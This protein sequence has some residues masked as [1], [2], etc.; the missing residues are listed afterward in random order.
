MRKTIGFFF[1]GLSASALACGGDD[2]H[3]AAPG[4]AASDAPASD[5]TNGND[6]APPIDGG[7]DAPVPVDANVDSAPPIT[8][9]A[10][11]TMTNASGGNHV[12]AFVRKADGSLTPFGAPFST[13]GTGSGQPLGSQGAIALDVGT[14]RLYAVNAG[15]G[16]FSVFPVRSDGSLAKALKVPG[17][18]ALVGPK[19]IT[20]SSDTVYVLYEGDATHPSAIAGY[21]VSGVG[22][23]AGSGVPIATSTL[24]LSNNTQSV[25]PAQIAFTPDGAYLV[26][27]EK[28]TNM[29]DTFSVDGTGLATKVGFYPTA[30]LGG[31][32]GAEQT[33]YGLAISGKV[34][35]VSEAASAGVGTYMLGVTGAV[36]PAGGGVQFL[37]TDPA[38]C[39]VASANG[40][41]YVANAQGPSVSGFTVSSTGGLAAIGSAAHAVVATTGQM[42]TIDGGT[43][44]QGPTDEAMS[45]DGKFLYVLDADVPAIGI[46][47][48]NV[49]GTLTRVGASD[50]SPGGVALFAGVQGLAA[51]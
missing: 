3:S 8:P 14:Q 48:V 23:D 13:L 2:T 41:A 16:S 40:F 43:V 7:S 11:Y 32:A 44:I 38:P 31:D 25:D 45:Q 27:T 20:F 51:R 49:D 29:I 17:T 19:S 30:T 33:P 50:Y 4:D 5:A 37:S 15:D 18:A 47:A 22:T 12:L 21:T 28:A 36:T 34:V 35:V 42:V 10:V 46:F 26:V 24:N 1:I 6:A 9:N 39:W